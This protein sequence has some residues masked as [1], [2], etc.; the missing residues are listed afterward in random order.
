MKSSDEILQTTAAKSTEQSKNQLIKT[1]KHQLGKQSQFLS[2]V[3]AF[4]QFVSPDLDNE[5]KILHDHLNDKV[6]FTLLNQNM[7]EV[8]DLLLRNSN[9][10]EQ[11]NRSTL[12]MLEKA[13]ETLY[14]LD[15]IEQGLKIDAANLLKSL[16]KKNTSLYISL[17]FFEQAIMLYQRTLES[18]Q[19]L[20][21]ISTQTKQADISTR[22]S[23]H[24]NIT[25]ELRQLL[26]QISITDDNRQSFTEI[27]L[28]LAQGINHKQLLESCL[29]VIKAFIND[30]LKERRHTQKTVTELHGSLTNINVQVGRSIE[31]AEIQDLEKNKN[32]EYL[33]QSIVDF[34]NTVNEETDIASLKQRTNRYLA[35]MSK[36]IENSG[37]ASKS[38]Q[39]EMMDILG[40][41]Q[42]QLQRLEH[43][44]SVYKNRLVK[45]EQRN[46]RDEL[47]NIP[48]RLAY[49][50]RIKLEY[51]RWKRY[52]KD[53]C[54]VVLDIDHFKRVNDNYGHAA[55]DKTLQVIA[56]SIADCLRA[57]DFLFRWG[58]EEFV[59]L[60]PRSDINE[61]TRLLQRISQ[62]IK[63]TPFK[64]KEHNITI[65]VSI[66]ATS[67]K[68]GDTIE[69]V[70]E[71]ADENLFQAKN[72][73]R[74][75]SVI[76]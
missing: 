5:L 57:T 58:G 1:F 15:D 24:Y 62:R 41:M 69:S 23:L 30:L 35:N 50:E 7:G 67:F 19:A 39:R 2:Q 47:T 43:Y 11:Q 27:Q 72:S 33:Q 65:T 76:S 71:R 52:G 9:V 51:A 73:G 40:D 54:M 31:I 6:E 8:S 36:T 48:N 12:S 18:S 14:D 32:Q 59:L 22:D 25:L 42:A 21:K 49:N 66:G 74:N 61:I 68:S 56:K 37:Q 44:T 45:Q 38:Q 53:L 70:F 3:I 64:Y 55:G 17:P 20:N 13:I 46:Y 26:A 29:I 34:E 63:L 28:L 60:L 16:P 4:Y 10:I 75:K